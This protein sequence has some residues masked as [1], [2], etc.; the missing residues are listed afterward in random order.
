MDVVAAVQIVEHVPA[1]TYKQLPPLT[2]DRRKDLVKKAK[3][4]AEHAK[5][6]IRNARRDAN[7]AVKKLIKK[8]IT[9]DEAKGAED[10]EYIK[11]LENDSK[12]FS[13]RLVDKQKDFENKQKAIKKGQ[14]DLKKVFSKIGRAHV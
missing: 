2:E 1:A 8:A 7:E 9:E 6:T 14:E 11:A 10:D 12:D 4:E 13:K 5:V 3:A